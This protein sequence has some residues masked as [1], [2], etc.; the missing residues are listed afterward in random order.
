MPSLPRRRG[1]LWPAP[2]VTLALSVL[3]A[4]CQ[5]W[6][7]VP[8]GQPSISYPGEPPLVRV[9]RNG[10]SRIALARSR[11]VGDSIAGDSVGG[12]DPHV[13][14]RASPGQPQGARVAV[15][16][17]DVRRLEQRRSEVARAGDAVVLGAAV[18]GAALL[19]LLYTVTSAVD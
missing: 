16:L 14:R 8:V 17:R 15:A 18:A 6:R 13:P 4:G 2:V 7:R 3:V 10:G 19:A 11:I 1:I 12:P 9:T 5:P